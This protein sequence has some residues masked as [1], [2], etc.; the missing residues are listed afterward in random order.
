MSEP[1]KFMYNV[2][3][4]ERLVPVLKEVIPRF[5][6]RKFVYSVFDTEW[7]DLE[8]KQ[9]TRQVTRALHRSLPSEYP[10]AVEM[11]IAISN[12][13]RTT[14]K[15]QSYPFIFLPEYIELYGMDHFSLSMK[16]IEEST[17]LVSAEFAIRPYI[18]R[19]PKE[20]MATMLSWSKHPEACVRRLASEGCR[21]RLPWAMG[22]PD[23]KKDPGPILPILENLKN[24]SSEYVRRSVANNLNDIAKDHPD[25]ALQIAKKWKGVNANTDWIIKHG[26][27]T[28]LKRGHRDVLNLHGFDPN[29]KASVK[30]F[31]LPRE[32]PLGETL[33]FSFTF[34]SREKKST[35]FRLEYAIDYIT[36]SGKI[37][38]KIFKL[39]ENT[40]EPFDSVEFRKRQ[41]FKDLTTRKHFKGKHRL[42]ILAN[43]KELI[44]SE[45]LVT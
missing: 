2:Q 20:T 7:A 18:I 9:R 32:L 28:L 5:E 19:Y 43:G 6:E 21:P 40:F 37:S 16:A 26:C 15:A 10:K 3:F 8:L 38:R 24:D 11:V 31:S 27:R 13:L 34:F 30:K 25:L 41:S 17:K 14:E 12:L 22:L 45:F 33:D 4:F 39:T 23:F 1:L 35:R 42:R 44:G 36:Q 29:A